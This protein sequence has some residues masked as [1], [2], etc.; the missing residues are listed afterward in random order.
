MGLV[1]G[2][3]VSMVFGF[4]WL[5]LL[6]YCAK[7]FV[8]LTI[9]LIVVL[10]TTLTIFFY[11]KAGMV[12]ME[13]P[14]TEDSQSEQMMPPEIEN[15]QGDSDF[16]RWCGIG[17][18]ALLIVSLVTIATAVKKINVASQIIAEASSAVGQM[19]AMMLY[20]MLPVTLISIVF[21]WF[22]YVAACLYS[23]ESI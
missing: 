5:V 13:A 11:H 23:I 19:K 17:M 14:V 10:Q 22:L 6:R 7:V 3:A 18:T 9:V 20:P 16:F 12:T 21:V 15:A 4:I 8:R 2:I 1:C